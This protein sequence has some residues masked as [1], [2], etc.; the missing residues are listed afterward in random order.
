MIITA[1][2]VRLATMPRFYAV[3]V[4]SA[5][6]PLIPP[7]IAILMG[8]LPALEVIQTIVTMSVPAYLAVPENITAAPR[9]SVSSS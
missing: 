9:E 8:V 3:H 6:V 1:L 2:V 5:Q 7:S 4:E